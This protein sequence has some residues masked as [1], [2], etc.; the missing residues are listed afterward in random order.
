MDAASGCD[1]GWIV[2]LQWHG[3]TQ[4]ASVTPRLV[5]RADCSRRTEPGGVH[6]QRLEEPFGD[7]CFPR[8]AG[9]LF[10]H[11]ADDGVALVRI[12]HLR[13][14][15][16]FRRLAE[17]SFNELT[18]LLRWACLFVPKPVSMRPPAVRRERR[19]DA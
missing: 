8:C 4:F 13:S 3:D 9:E 17:D 16:G 18:A 2:R 14:G 1:G 19:R 10:Q 11:R 15:R 6:V 12:N 7:Q 5:N